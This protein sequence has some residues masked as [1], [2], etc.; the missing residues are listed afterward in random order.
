[1][2]T[3]IENSLN[4]TLKNLNMPVVKFSLQIPKNKEHGDLATN[5]AFLLSKEFGDNPLNIATEIKTELEKTNLFSE[6]SIANPGFINMKIN[7]EAIVDNLNFIISKEN[8]YGANNSGNSKKVLLEFVSANPT[9]PLTV[10]HGRGAIIGDV[11]SNAYKWN[12]YHVNR[13]YYYNNAGRQMKILAESVLA[14]YLE[15]CNR[16]FIF[17]EDG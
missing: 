14:R 16:K 12:G 2:K 11:I 13:E 7:P 15:I 3:I 8:K 17:P 9:G 6:V 5:I 10:G 4:K 1:M